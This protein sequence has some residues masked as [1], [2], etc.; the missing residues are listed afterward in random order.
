M[1]D[2]LHWAVDRPAHVCMLNSVWTLNYSKLLHAL[3]Y[4]DMATGIKDVKDASDTFVTLNNNSCPS[5][6]AQAELLW[7]VF[8]LCPE[9]KGTRGPC[10]TWLPSSVPS[11]A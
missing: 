1:D 6:P 3:S 5:L 2:N 11:C 4:P 10:C 9:R 8:F 7:G